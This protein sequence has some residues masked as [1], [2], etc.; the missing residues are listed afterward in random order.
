MV[1]EKNPC[2]KEQNQSFHCLTENNYNRNACAGYFENYKRC[3]DF[4]NEVRVTRRREGIQPNLPPA[5]EREQ[6]KRDLL[7]KSRSGTL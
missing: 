4:W 5:E 3:K 1:D 7:N 6:I 2:L